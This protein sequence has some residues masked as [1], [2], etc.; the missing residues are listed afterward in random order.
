MVL[1]SHVCGLHSDPARGRELV[2]RR[3]PIS[4]PLDHV[5]A[6]QLHE[7]SGRNPTVNFHGVESLQFSTGILTL[8]QIAS[9]TPSL[10]VIILL[11]NVG[12]ILVRF[13]YEFRRAVSQPNAVR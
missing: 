13:V 11:T 1:T 9:R 6:L 3:I 7:V 4:C 5:H 10:V 8:I 12:K 2:E